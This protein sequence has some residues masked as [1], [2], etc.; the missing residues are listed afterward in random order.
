MYYSY[1][2][3]PIGRLFIGEKSSKISYISM[4]YVDGYIEK[5]TDILKE[6]K[7]QLT[8]YF[9]KKR[10]VFDI[11]IYLDGTDFQV[12][13][14]KALQTIPYGETKNYKEVAK[15]IGNPNA[16]RAVGNANNKN[17]ILIIVPCHRVIG[18]T[19]GLVGFG[20][21]IDNKQ[22]LLELEKDML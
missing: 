6:C 11:P 8:E 19:G 2:A 17:K 21:G 14:W 13:V 10:T 7:K 18:A 16:S 3:S 9:N 22:L 20:A 12:S 4:D 5:E 1:L 15:L